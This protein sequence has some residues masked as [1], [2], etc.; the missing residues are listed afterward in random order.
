ML[1]FARGQML[2]FARGQM[3]VFAAGAARPV[4]RRCPRGAIQ[5][6]RLGRRPRAAVSVG[7]LERPRRAVSDDGTSK[8]QALGPGLSAGLVS[9]GT[10]PGQG[11]D[12]ALSR[13][14][15]QT[16][17]HTPRPQTRAAPRPR[18]ALALSG[19]PAAVRPRRPSR[20][21]RGRESRDHLAHGRAVRTPPPSWDE[22]AVVRLPVRAGDARCAA[23]KPP[24][25]LCRPQAESRMP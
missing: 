19:L 3:F 23:R 2:V 16:R 13:P 9:A 5:Q 24:A 15:I 25:A 17:R 18:G 21:G 11:R 8:V 1:V 6:Q 10:R 12:K 20:L 14:S 7:A 4:E 22:D